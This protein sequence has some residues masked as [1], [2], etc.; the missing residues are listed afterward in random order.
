MDRK[1]VLEAIKQLRT[2]EKRKFSQSVDLIINL[3]SFDVKRENLNLFL[4]MPHKIR[5]AKLAAF[6]EKKSNFIDTITKTE[7]DAYKDKKRIKALIKGY[8]FFISVPKLMPLV[9]SNFGR[10]LGPVGKMPS[11]QLGIIKE[12]SEGDI[13]EVIKKFEKI[14]RVKSKEPSLKFSIA[15]EDMKDEEIIDNIEFAFNH[16]LNALP[17]KKENIKSVMVKFTMTKP[18][19]IQY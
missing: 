1:H 3:R 4:N 8:D 5:E 7:F 19:K 9:A 10:F 15:R 18:V 11:P 2:N 16:I 6:F 17:K 13:K 12:E 14:V